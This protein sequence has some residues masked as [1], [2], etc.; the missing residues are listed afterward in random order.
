MGVRGCDQVRQERVLWAWREWRGWGMD[1]SW[2]PL[3]QR[4]WA[5]ETGERCR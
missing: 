1:V 4:G 3:V 2:P 5:D